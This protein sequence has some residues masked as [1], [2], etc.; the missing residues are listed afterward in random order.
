MI[1]SLV[2][3]QHSLLSSVLRRS[4]YLPRGNIVLSNQ[5]V[6]KSEDSRCMYNEQLWIQNAYISAK[7]FQITADII[8]YNMR[9]I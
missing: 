6:I 5:I 1:T 7:S 3:G 2:T 9:G 8:V 4:L